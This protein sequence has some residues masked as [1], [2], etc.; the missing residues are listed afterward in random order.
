MEVP[1]SLTG[2]TPHGLAQGREPERVED[3]WRHGGPTWGTY[4]VKDT[5]T[6]PVVWRTFVR[7]FPNGIVGGKARASRFRLKSEGGDAD[8]RLTQ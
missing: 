4:H 8:E 6:G 3:L 7:T 1:R 5:E 2:W